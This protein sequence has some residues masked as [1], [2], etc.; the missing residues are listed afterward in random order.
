LWLLIGLHKRAQVPFLH[1]WPKHD[2]PPRRDR[3][4]H[5]PPSPI[6]ILL[7]AIALALVGLGK[8]LLR[9][10]TPRAVP[11]IPA[12][13]P[14]LQSASLRAGQLQIE[15]SPPPTTSLNLLLNDGKTR[16]T[17]T[18]P[19]SPTG[20]YFLDCQTDSQ[21]LKL[22][23][24]QSSATLVRI[25]AW[26]KIQREAPLGASVERVIA[27]YEKARKPS[28]NSPVLKISPALDPSESGI[29]PGQYQNAPQDP[30]TIDHP[31]T[32][33][34]K[35]WPTTGGVAPDGWTPLV[36]RGEKTLLAV[37]E[38][39]TARQAFL[40]MDFSNWDASPDFVIFWTNLLDYLA[41]PSPEYRF[42][43]ATLNSHPETKP[44]D[45][46]LAP[47]LWSFACAL[48]LISSLLFTRKGS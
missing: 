30:F 10:N 46:P 48:G 43:P 16:Q 45:I 41:G 7:L 27:S 35:T 19:P 4:L 38:T 26:P 23:I 1:L 8:P 28:E 44:R 42:I 33:N 14:I 18:L 21:T 9:K 29:I 15:L 47:W 12:P 3:H 17:H 2:A 40:A 13:R 5:F 11:N 6:L 37:R 32:A 34:V 31:V 25:G 36:K 20:L 39:E 22:A 24:D